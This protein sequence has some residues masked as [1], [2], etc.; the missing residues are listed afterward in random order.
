MW[1]AARRSPCAGSRV[2]GVF[3]SVG[4]V[5]RASAHEGA[6]GGLWTSYGGDLGS[7]KYSPL[8]QIDRDN[9][10]DLKIAWEWTSVDARVSRSVP[11]GGEWSGRDRAVFEALRREHP[12]LWRGGADPRHAPPMA[13]LRRGGGGLWSGDEA[14][15]GRVDTV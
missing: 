10:S 2:C 14:Q 4:C 12:H 6:R 1:L 11:G 8:D 3:R 7:T 13:T 5:G 15:A 9:F